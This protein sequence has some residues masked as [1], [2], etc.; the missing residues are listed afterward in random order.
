MNEVNESVNKS[1]IIKLFAKKADLSEQDATL[2]TDMI[3]SHITHLLSQQKQVVF[4][5]FGRFFTKTTRPYQARNP[6]NGD[7][8]TVE[9]KQKIQFKASKQ[10]T[11][12]INEKLPS[13]VKEIEPA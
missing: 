6:R 8:L 7:S 5:T 13:S 1:E 4:R 3:L 12:M 9:E 2:I 11:V 10:L